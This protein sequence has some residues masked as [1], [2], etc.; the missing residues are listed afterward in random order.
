MTSEKVNVARSSAFKVLP[1][2]RERAAPLLRGTRFETRRRDIQRSVVGGRSKN[3]RLLAKIKHAEEGYRAGRRGSGI[4]AEA[5]RARERR[6]AERRL[7]RRRARRK[8]G[9]QNG[10]S[11]AFAVNTMWEEEP[12]YM[13]RGLGTRTPGIEAHVAL[14]NTT[15]LLLYKCS[16]VSIYTPN[17]K[18]TRYRCKIC[19]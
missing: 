11:S 13:R 19:I 12:K 15:S 2:L 7:E 10:S 1:S 4:I 14:R 6:A 9:K 8:T 17:K 5:R 18:S 16:V 3:E